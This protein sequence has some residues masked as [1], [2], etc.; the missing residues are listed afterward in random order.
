MKLATLARL[1]PAAMLFA[2]LTAP[3][4]A[5]VE[6][7]LVDVFG[8]DSGWSVFLPDQTHNGVVIDAVTDT[9]VRIEIAKG[10][11]LPPVN[12][13]FPAREFRFHQRL[14]DGSTVATIQIT[15]EVIHNGTGVDWTDYHW[16]IAAGAAAFD[17]AATDAS[18]FDVSPFTTKVWGCPCAE[19]PDT[20][21]AR[22]LDVYDGVVPDG[23]TFAPGLAAGKLYI[24][25]N[26]APC[27]SDFSLV[28]RPTPEPAALGLM[29][30]GLPALLI[31]IRR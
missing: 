12:G 11:W 3:T 31:R 30:L 26:L 14:D 5:D 4:P 22:S 19:W 21:H 15:D 2:A 8:N 20:D 17:T 1:I 7:P 18:G 23:G 10:F 28:Q 27:N 9:F 16:Q 29:C 25:A 6:I 13:V 24:D